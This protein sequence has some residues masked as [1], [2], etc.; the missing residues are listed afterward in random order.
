MNFWIFN[1]YAIPP[2][3]SGITRDYDLA[4][5]L[6]EKGVKVTIFA[7]SFDHRSRKERHFSEGEKGYFKIE[8]IDGVRYVWI[9]TTPYHGNNLK[10]VMNILSYS[11]KGYFASKRLKENPD[12]VMGTIV[13]PLA[14]FLGYIVSKRKKATFYFEERDLWPETLI[15]LGKFN[16]KNPIVK[17]L[18]KLELFLY[19]KAKRIIL[20]F[21]RAHLYVK[22]RGINVGKVLYIP[23]GVDLNRYNQK[24]ALPLE[25]EEKLSRFKDKYVGVYAGAHGLANNLEVLLEVAKITKQKNKDI[26]F[27]FIGDGVE[28]QN[29]MKYAEKEQ[30]DNVTFM[31]PVP[32]EYIPSILSRCQVGLISLLDAELYKWGTSLNKV[33]DY[34]AASLPVFIKC[35]TEETIVEKAKCGFKVKNVNEMVEKLLY[36]YEHQNELKM[37]GNNGRSYVEQ[38][39]S[40]DH[41]SQTLIKAM[42]DDI[43]I[44]TY[45]RE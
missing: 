41:L 28:K 7:S 25:I 1:H 12:I 21:D 45:E 23:N 14:A 33:Y 27:L 44:K 39:H 36:A 31:D 42:Y 26:H 17:V 8:E 16:K 22:S 34:M 43:K 40:W 32:K 24:K 9:R 35:N 20:L 38:Y 15:H 6:I 13:H 18:Y 5:R 19:R 29:L 37:M 30:L 3:A 4:K 10:R 2:N 11:I